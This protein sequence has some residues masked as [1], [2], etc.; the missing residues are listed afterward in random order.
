MPSTPHFAT[1]VM[2]PGTTRRRKEVP[3]DATLR[4]RTEELARRMHEL[5]SARVTPPAVYAKK[6]DRCSLYDRC[7]PRTASK[8]DAVKRYLARELRG[9][10]VDS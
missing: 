7:L 10:E 4:T 3:L 8:R 2:M 1:A 5:Y 9:G 6:C